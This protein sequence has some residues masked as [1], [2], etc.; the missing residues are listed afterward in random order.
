MLRRQG[1]S[2]YLRFLIQLAYMTVNIEHQHPAQ[3]TA[4][5]GK[6]GSIGVIGDILAPGFDPFIQ[7]D[8]DPG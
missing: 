8:E 4:N 5:G 6:V 7:D 2:E 3:I 1:G